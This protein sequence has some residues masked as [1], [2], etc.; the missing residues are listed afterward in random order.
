MI[1][2]EREIAKEL[3][4][5][6]LKKRAMLALKKKKFLEKNL[7]QTDTQLLNLEQLVNSIQVHVVVA[8]RLRMNSGVLSI[9]LLKCKRKCS[10]RFRTVWIHALARF[11]VE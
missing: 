2:R 1:A 11:L 3:Y 8:M 6:G 7:A 9:S 5:K 10:T 4:R